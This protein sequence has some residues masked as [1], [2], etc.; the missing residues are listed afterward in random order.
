MAKQFK[1]L[2]DIVNHLC[3]GLTDDEIMNIKKGGIQNPFFGMQLRNSF[4]LWWTPDTYLKYTTNLDKFK[5]KFFG[6]KRKNA[7]Y[8]PT[9][10]PIVQWFHNHGFYHADDMSSVIIDAFKAK[11]NN[12]D[13]DIAK[14]YQEIDKYWKNAGINNMQKEFAPW[15]L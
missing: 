7:F 1:N 3:K 9:I 11:V 14:T 12:E 4:G 8:S 13:Y 2:N 6:I 10:P 5:Y 15:S